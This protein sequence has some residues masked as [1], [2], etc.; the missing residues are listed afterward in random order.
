MNFPPYDAGLDKQIASGYDPVRYSMIALAVN[1]I[2]KD[3]IKGCFAEVG[4]WQGTTSRFIHLLAPERVL[5]LFDTFEGFPSMDL[6]HD[7]GDDRFKDTGVDLVRKTIGDMKNVEIK[8]GYFPDTT[9]GLE[10]VNFAFVLLDLDLYKPTKA[11]LEFFYPRVPA[12]GYIFA[13]DYNSPESNWAISRAV[14]EFLSGKPE[15]LVEIPDEWG[16]V[17]FRK[18]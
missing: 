2:K 8:K 4:V 5:Y 16:S 18:I 13:H 10:A 7:R 1:R 3:G 11:G 6:E 15:K 17:L 9:C 12:G 14:N